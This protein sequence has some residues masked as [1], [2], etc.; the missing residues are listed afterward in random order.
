MSKSPID[1]VP[2]PPQEVFRIISNRTGEAVGSYS[3]A[4]HDEFDFGS[5]ESAREANCHGMFKDKKEYRIAKYRVVYELI[6]DDVD[7]S[8]PFKYDGPTTD[9]SGHVV[10]YTL[11]THEGLREA[12][13]RHLVEVFQSTLDNKACGHSLPEKSKEDDSGKEGA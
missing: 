1:I 7:Q 2:K 3:R 6:D 12:F 5:V 13:R 9:E 4:C 10:N 11:F 8:E